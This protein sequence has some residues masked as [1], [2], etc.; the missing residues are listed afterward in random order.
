MELARWET[1]LSDEVDLY[2]SDLVD[3]GGRL[4]IH[5]VSR[6]GR[7]YAV[8]FDWVGPYLVLDEGYRTSYWSKCRERVGATFI[9]H[10]SPLIAYFDQEP[11]FRIECPSP[12]HLVIATIDVV[13]EVITNTRPL[14]KAYG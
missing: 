10:E 4:I 5:V 7:K 1:S 9:V 3:K 14:I 13:I 12:E 11:T 8:N 6:T 2:F